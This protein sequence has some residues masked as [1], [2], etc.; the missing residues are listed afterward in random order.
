MNAPLRRVGVVVLVLFG[1]L[2]AN[3]NWVQAYKADEY[4]TSDYN[5]RVQ[6]AEYERQRG[7]SSRPATRAGPEQG[8]HGRA[9]VPARRTRSAPTYAHVVGY[10]PVNLAATGI[11]QHGERVP[12][13]HRRHARRRPDPGDVHRR[14]DPGGNVL[15]TL[16]QAG[17]GDRVQGSCSD[18][19]GRRQGGAV[20]ALDPATGAVLALVSMPS[21]DPN[22][23]V[24]HDTD[25]GRGGLRQARQG[26]RQA[27]AQ[28]GALRDVPARLDVQGDRR[29]GGAGERL[30]PADADPGRPGLPRRRPPAPTSATPPG[31]DLPGRRS[32]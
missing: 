7:R 12:R 25:G 16:S 11:E 30:H 2:F 14:E 18:N 28:P 8:D 24:S 27:A 9:E 22:P 31:V 6:I 5:G 10:K 29:G 4:R 23:L 1:L 13:R 3:L 20:V 19:R 17:P 21:F 26:P 32:P 15:L